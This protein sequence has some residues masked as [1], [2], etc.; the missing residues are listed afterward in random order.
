MMKNQVGYKQ[1]R[2]IDIRHKFIREFVQGGTINLTYCPTSD[3]L[4]DIFTKPLP[5]TQFEKLRE[6]LGLINN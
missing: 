4:A 1:S 6:N 3:M 2:H 5:K